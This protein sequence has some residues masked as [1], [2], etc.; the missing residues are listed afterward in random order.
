[1]KTIL[2]M[3]GFAAVVQL[4][5]FAANATSS[6]YVDF[7]D[8][9]VHGNVGFDLKDELMR[10]YPGIDLR[11]MVLVGVDVYAKSD[12]NGADASVRVGPYATEWSEIYGDPGTY[13]DPSDDT[14]DMLSFDGPT[15]LRDSTFMSW[16]LDVDGDAIVRGVEVYMDFD[17]MNPGTVRGPWPDRIHRRH[18]RRW[19]GHG[20]GHRRGDGHG[21]G[22]GG[23]PCLRC[24]GGHGGHRPHPPG[25]GGGNPPHKPGKPGKP[26]GNPPHK[27]GKPPGQK[28][29]P[30]NGGGGHKPPPAK[31]PGQKPPRPPGNGGGQKP[32][33]PPGQKPPR[34]PGNGGGGHGGGGHGG[35]HGGGG[36][37][38]GGHGGG[39]HE[40]M[41]DDSTESIDN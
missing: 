23:Q 30:G 27:P 37:G 8:Y 4:A 34:P 32:P 19:P 26:P 21:P 11:D 1:M 41:T 24:G 7:G 16:I 2:K 14:F 13:G 9:Q 36:H 25:N 18:G 15:S 10:Q 35:G 40:P 3:V 17:P 6:L 22:H 20:G 31:P 33:K 29:P 39:H 5:S 38:G 12:V 28:P